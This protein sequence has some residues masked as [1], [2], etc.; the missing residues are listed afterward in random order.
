[1]LGM[2]TARVGRGCRSRG[3]SAGRLFAATNHEP[4]SS[5]RT[6][7]KSKS[8]TRKPAWPR[9]SPA[10]L[11]ATSVVRSSDSS[12]RTTGTPSRVSCTSSSQAAAP[13]SQAQ[14]GGFERVL[15]CP[16]RIAPMR[17]DDRMIAICKQSR[18]QESIRA[19]VAGV[20]TAHIDGIVAGLPAR[21]KHRPRSASLLDEQHLLI[22]RQ[23]PEVVGDE[24]LRACRRRR[25]RRS[26]RG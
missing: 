20:Q 22:G 14:P 19:P 15:G 13:A 10:N 23:R 6:S 7:S 5:D 11:A 25:G 1:M 8:E 4:A 24:E 26:W 16:E 2:R 21:S 18:A 17:H 3:P 12:W 9:G